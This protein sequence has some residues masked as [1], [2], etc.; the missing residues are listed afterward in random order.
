MN[1]SAILLEEELTCWLPLGLIGLNKP[2]ELNKFINSHVSHAVFP[3][4][5][6]MC[7]KHGPKLTQTSLISKPRVGFHIRVI[8]ELST[9]NCKVLRTVFTN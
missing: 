7:T 5:Q 9:G 4:Y 8:F 2:R 3:I 6:Y 1:D